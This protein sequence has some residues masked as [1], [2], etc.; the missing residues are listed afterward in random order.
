MKKQDHEVPY[1][2]YQPGDIAAPISGKFVLGISVPALLVLAVVFFLPWAKAQPVVVNSPPTICLTVE[3]AV[4]TLESAP[5]EIRFAKLEVVKG[6]DAVRHADKLFTADDDNDQVTALIY[7]YPPGGSWVR[8]IWFA[9]GCFG[10]HV[11]FSIAHIEKALGRRS[12]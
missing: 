9:N 12:S 8:V 10:A 11:D 6:A 3:A 4:S 2:G 5:R 7:A 1:N